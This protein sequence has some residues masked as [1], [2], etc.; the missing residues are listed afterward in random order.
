MGCVHPPDTYYGM[1]WHEGRNIIT[2]SPDGWYGVGYREG[3]NPYHHADH[4]MRCGCGEDHDMWGPLR[5][6]EV[7]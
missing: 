2:T 5:T 4:L 7:V 6:G 3:R 1:G